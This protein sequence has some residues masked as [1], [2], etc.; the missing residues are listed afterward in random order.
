MKTIVLAILFLLILQKPGI[1]KELDNISNDL[2]TI[3]RNNTTLETGQRASVYIVYGDKNFSQNFGKDSDSVNESY[4]VGDLS[5]LFIGAQIVRLSE[6]GK[7]SLDDS[8]FKYLPEL[9]NEYKT[10][11]KISDLLKDHT[12]LPYTY[13]YKIKSTGDVLN[14]LKSNE[15]I[16]KY[17]NVYNR[18]QIDSDILLLIIER[19]EKSNFNDSM[20]SLFKKFNLSNTNFIDSQKSNR[21]SISDRLYSSPENIGQFISSIMSDK[22]LSKSVFARFESTS[23]DQDLYFTPCFES[24]NITLIDQNNSYDKYTLFYQYDKETNSFIFA[25]PEKKFAV[26]FLSNFPVSIA[27]EEYFSK[28]L[29]KTTV[30]DFLKMDIFDYRSTLSLKKVDE[31]DD[32]LSSY[33]GFFENKNGIIEFH[34]VDNNLM[35][36]MDKKFYN[37]KFYD[38]G[39]FSLYP[40]DSSNDYIKEFRFRF[41]YING[42]RYL[43]LLDFGQSLTFAREIEQPKY[44]D[45]WEDRL[46]KWIGS[47]NN[48]AIKEMDIEKFRGFYILK[49][50]E[51]AGKETNLVLVPVYDDSAKILDFGDQ[52]VTFRSEDQDS[53]F[54]FLG[55]KFIK[56]K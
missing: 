8:I 24:Q 13:P 28:E 14:F 39:S 36:N 29:L 20:D 35:C 48:S 40:V 26:I 42:T 49:Y 11:I 22:N 3:V 12:Y 1:S 32:Y 6:L 10:N 18:S 54:N 51:S 33:M 16:L 25:I 41:T 15:D 56:K 44:D 17:D 23:Y 30:K 47:D 52:I 19:V 55:I 2:S 21:L 43:S 27:R 34:V 7:I 46:G 31:K 50:D 9:K 4:D 45:A 37:V 53:S 5:R 38:D